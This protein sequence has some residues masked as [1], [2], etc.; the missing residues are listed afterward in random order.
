MYVWTVEGSW[1]N[2]RDPMYAQEKDHEETFCL[3][4]KLKTFSL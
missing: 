3:G 1:S 2:Q 4:F